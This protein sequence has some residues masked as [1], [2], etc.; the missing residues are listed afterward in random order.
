M[1]AVR[2]R[3]RRI[4]SN[5]T[6]FR[7]WFPDFGRSAKKAKSQE[8]PS[9]PNTGTA[10]LA[11]MTPD[12]HVGPLSTPT[13]R[14]AAITPDQLR[15]DADEDDAAP[16]AELPKGLEVGKC[17]VMSSESAAAHETG[18]RT[19]LGMSAILKH[20][21]GNRATLVY[22]GTTRVSVPLSSIELAGKLNTIGCV[23]AHLKIQREDR[24]RQDD[25]DCCLWASGISAHDDHRPRPDAKLSAMLVYWVLSFLRSA[26]R[27]LK[28]PCFE[29]AYR[30]KVVDHLF[31]ESFV[32]NVDTCVV[33]RQ[34]RR[35]V[36][37]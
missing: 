30:V 18:L 16:P 13:Q 29:P 15:T 6:T 23:Q 28:N 17:V 34:H 10:R 25:I 9:S 4:A 1:Q 19:W 35:L 7:R 20:V 37:G 11:A 2:K 21:R 5:R 36:T 8:T 3:K 24:L 33:A 26:R 14:L 22:G 27:I 31:V 12:Q 32:F